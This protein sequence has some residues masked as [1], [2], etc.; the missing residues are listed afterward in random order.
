MSIAHCALCGLNIPSNN[1][2]LWTSKFRAVYTDK[3]NWNQTR[4]SGVGT[5]NNDGAKAPRDSKRRFDDDDIQPTDLITID[6]ATRS[7]NKFIGPNPST[8]EPGFWGFGF[9]A[10][11]WGI[12]THLFQPSLNDLLQVCLSFP[13]RDRGILD[14]GH[15]YGGAIVIKED[16]GLPML[17]PRYFRGA[18]TMDPMRQDP[19]NLSAI[20]ELARSAIPEHPVDRASA[21]EVSCQ[22]SGVD[23][24]N[25]LPPELIAA[26]LEFVPSRYVLCVKLA[27]RPF[28]ACPLTESFWASR[29][30][31]GN[32]FHH[33]F[34]VWKSKPKSWASMHHALRGIRNHR[35]L[36][37]RK[38][39]WDLSLKLRDLLDQLMPICH[40]DSLHSYFEPVENHDHLDWQ[41][42][43]R[44]LARP[45]DEFRQGT[46]SLRT[47]V[48]DI[49]QD[50]QEVFVSFVQLSLGEFV[51]GIRFQRQNGDDV[52]IGY[53][54]ASR[55]FP[56][57]IPSGLGIRGLF[58]AFSEMGVQAISALMED[59]TR[60]PWRGA[61]QGLP[62]MRLSAI[63]RLTALKGEFDAFKLVALSIPIISTN[64][65][66]PQETHLW[67]DIPPDHL[68]LNGSDDEFPKTDYRHIPLP[69]S[70]VLFGGAYGQDLVQLVQIRWTFYIDV[71]S[72]LQFIYT[73]SSKNKY[74]GGRDPFAESGRERRP[75]NVRDNEQLFCIDG[76]AGELITSIEVQGGKDRV[77][78]MTL[79][80]NF[81]RKAT[82][83]QNY[84]RGGSAWTVVE[85][86]GD[87]I[88]GFYSVVERGL[89][90]VGLMSMNGSAASRL[91]DIRAPNCS[92]L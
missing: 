19:F 76:P 34:E 77:E 62:K 37:S 2:S 21:I 84:L 69:Y 66:P 72:A 20:L 12:L 28:A 53:T 58:L 89:R 45:E 22:A 63:F 44:G 5:I 86:E 57:G 15:T 16:D 54:E 61:E 91:L 41:V 31:E 13:L 18:N 56:L 36:L 73:D 6:L 65:I 26:I 60:S 51:S 81:G 11:C 17:L 71:I 24:F 83:P 46:R 78:G 30:L 32:D 52:R 88:V 79:K 39:V 50:V 7:F 10:S 40:G 48:I 35:K 75:K 29:F 23:P 68:Y 8:Q 27:S 43:S 82:F 74:F 80:T 64:K 85:P 25:L 59:D 9:H 4:L 67:D 1:S 87:V 3:E 38:R 33:V 14:W 70:T 55:E 90:N 92:I 49:P 42:A 47:R